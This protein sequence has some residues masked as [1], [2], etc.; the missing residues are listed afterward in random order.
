MTEIKIKKEF[1]A[2]KSAVEIKQNLNYNCFQS[3]YTNTMF[4]VLV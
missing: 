3:Y 2:P 1:K 4:I